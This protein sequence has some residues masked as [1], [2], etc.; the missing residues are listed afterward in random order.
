MNFFKAEEFL[1]KCGRP[2]CDAL[3]Y[4]HPDLIDKLNILREFLKVPLIITSGLRCEFRNRQEGGVKDSEHLVGEAVDI[5]CTTSGER[6]RIAKYGPR[7][8]FHRVGIG[9]TFVHLDLSP[10]KPQNVLWLY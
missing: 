9:K 6:F 7:A 2:E 10:T 1:C 5:A 3:R 8:G 4:V